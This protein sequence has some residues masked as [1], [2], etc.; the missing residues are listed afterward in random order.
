MM[1]F[2]VALKFTNPQEILI[3]F[4]YILLLTGLDKGMVVFATPK[5]IAND[6]M[7][8]HGWGIPL[9]TQEL[10]G[11]NSF[12]WETHDT[13]GNLGIPSKGLYL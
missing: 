13:C 3:Y 7:S 12:S 1:V 6:L 4:T 11:C 9:G 10:L 5:T 2:L 8:K